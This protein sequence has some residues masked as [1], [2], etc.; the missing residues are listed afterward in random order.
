MLVSIQDHWLAKLIQYANALVG[1]AIGFSLMLL[2]A[3]YEE[4]LN[5]LVK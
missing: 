3:L 2:I 1:M 5:S 4:Q